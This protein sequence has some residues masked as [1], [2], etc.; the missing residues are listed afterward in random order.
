MK[1]SSILGRAQEL[2][3][4]TLDAEYS[5]A[6]LDGLEG[7]ALIEIRGIVAVQQTWLLLDGRQAERISLDW[8]VVVVVLH[9][10]EEF[11]CETGSITRTGS[12]P[13]VST[14]RL[15]LPESTSVELRIGFASPNQG[16]KLRA[17]FGHCEIY[18]G[19][20]ERLTPA[21]PNLADMSLYSA[22]EFLPNFDDDFVP[23]GRLTVA[24]GDFRR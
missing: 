3:I 7:T 10:V 20:I 24:P 11:V 12:W 6:S 8:N 5:P 23:A 15:E 4:P 1:I 13:G 22:A 9:A 16:D 17:R 19:T 21:P 18:V 14:S 2:A